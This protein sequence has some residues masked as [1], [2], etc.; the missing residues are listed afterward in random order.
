MTS[1]L[2]LSAYRS[3]SHALWATSV[4]HHLTADWRCLE[5][6]GRH[7]RWRI[8]GNPLSWLPELH[9]LLQDWQP[10]HILATSMVD[11][12]TIKGL[13]PALAKVPSSYYFHENQFAYPVSS[14][15]HH[16]IDPQMVQMYGA[17]AA[18]RLLFNSMFN[19]DTFLAGVDELLQRLP[20]H[21]PEGISTLLQQRSACLPVPVAPIERRPHG[22]RSRPLLLWNHR[23]EYDKR[24]DLFLQLL[25]QL[26][27]RQQPVDVALL[28]GR[29]QSVNPALEI[30]RQEFS[31]WI[32]VDDY[33]DR[34][35]YLHWLQQADLVFSCAEHEFQGVAML[36]AVSAGALPVVPD[37]LCYREQYPPQCR[38]PAGDMAAA[39]ERIVAW[40][41][42]PIVDISNWLQPATGEMWRQWLAAIR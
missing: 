3:D 29:S 28:G 26:Q 2:M 27:Q 41:Q 31:G 14:G 22:A 23:W 21:V 42:L 13:F 9:A 4:Q 15:Q 18:E 1:I 37:A 17:L 19:R 39:A 33:P 36:E 30:I 34:S 10:Q 35:Q 11:L 40:Q 5:L 24:P 25:R 12:A 20:D 38:Y 32:V 6:P 7:F 16:S 8:R